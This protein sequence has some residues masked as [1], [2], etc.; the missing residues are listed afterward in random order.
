MTSLPIDEILPAILE[1]ALDRGR[2]GFPG[3]IVEAPPGAG[4]TTRVPIALADALGAS[5]G[6][7]I[8]TEPRRVAATLSAVRVAEERGSEL[9]QE[10]GYRVRFDE[11]ASESS[12]VVYLTEGLLLRRLMSDPELKGVGVVIFD[13]VHER[14]AILDLLLALTT[15]LAET[16]KRRLFL[17]SMSATLDAVALEDYWPGA[18]RVRSE[19]RAFPVSVHFEPR[20]DDR[21]LEIQVR[22]AVRAALGAS[23]SGD[24]LV[25]LPGAL[26]IRSAAAALDQF[27][28]IEVIAL[29]GDQPLD[30]QTRVLRPG[31]ARGKRRV[32]LATN[33]AETS[34]TIPGVT[35]VIDS[36]LARVQRFDSFAGV[37]RLTTVEISQARLIQRAG[38]A[39]RTAPGR[40]FRL[41][42]EASFAARPSSDVPEIRRTSLSETLLILRGFGFAPG[43]VRWLTDPGASA[44]ERAEEELRSIGALDPDHRL[45]PVGKRMLELPLSLRPARFVVEA[46]VR[47][48]ERVGLL[49]AL[50]S[51]RDPLQRSR[52]VRGGRES[53]PSD[54]LDRLERVLDVGSRVDPERCRYHELD[55]N[56]VAQIYRI[57]KQV[58]A[59]LGRDRARPAPDQD[60]VLTAC[61]LAAFPNRV[62][63]R[64]GAQTEL[65]SVDG[66]V[67]ELD[68]ASVVSA[69]RFLIAVSWDAPERRGATTRTRP[70]VRLAHSVSEDELMSHLGEQVTPRE[71]YEW[72]ASAERVDVRSGF[73]L[74]AVTLDESLARARPGPDAARELMRVLSTKGPKVYD[75]EARLEGL[76]VRLS[77]LKHLGADLLGE[78]ARSEL[79]ALGEGL[80]ELDREAL[81]AA[82]ESRVSLAEVVEI[83]LDAILEAQRL[84]R[85]G[86][87]LD[88]LFPRE[89]VLFGGKRLKVHYEEA[90][91]PWIESRLQDFFSMLDTPSVCRGR[92][93]LA[94]QLLAPNYRPVQVTSDLA[95]FWDRHYPTLRKELMRRY[96]KHL[97]PE[98]GKTARPPTPG[99]IR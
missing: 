92:L 64:R 88:R 53:G 32:V 74:G 65:L 79:D 44:F 31:G 42:T 77:L 28:G 33:I 45:T 10:I 59:S 54:L 48:L 51:E 97:W 82:G 4:K 95:G 41:F 70:V 68:R 87:E 5:E 83:E 38:R 73:Y 21:P 13:E 25:F 18:P 14:S 46:E 19:G 15:R 27:E 80:R 69:G 55:R 81:E 23:D 1:C 99:K 47:G 35:T 91:P 60:A 8:V 30:E 67:A 40:V 84:P 9:G 6:Q 78:E 50:L 24:F 36:G 56:A 37:D 52:E 7:V 26:E 17:V 94:I 2:V 86:R 58:D 22:S 66:F 89:V 76:R 12:R 75:P 71:S 49:V 90:K 63:Q 62:C 61:L 96:P 93:T 34:V 16:R 85:L 29:H 20:P 3:I 98:D 72:N 43:D 57:A 39:G 11:K